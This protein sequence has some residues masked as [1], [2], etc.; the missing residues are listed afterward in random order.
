MD[1]WNRVIEN[2]TQKEPFIEYKAKGNDM[3]QEE[4]KKNV[5]LSRLTPIAD[6]IK[7]SIADDSTTEVALTSAMAGAKNL[8]REIDEYLESRKSK[9]K[10]GDYVIEQNGNAISKIEKVTD[11]YPYFLG[12]YYKRSENYITNGS[13]DIYSMDIERHATPEEITEYKVALNFY[14][15]GRKPFEV[16]KNDIVS[17]DDN[18]HIISYPDQ[19]A[20]DGFVVR[21]VTLL[22]TA[23]ELEE[24]LGA[25]DE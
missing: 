2:F 19:W 17:I 11:H 10:V 4:N 7:T 1:A 18:K 25:D 24:W 20:K 15:H 13:V 14:E 8:S 22:K 23:E 16:K 9:F 5:L 12:R 3:I 6:A 21:G